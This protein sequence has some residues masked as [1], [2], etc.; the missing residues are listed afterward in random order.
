MFIVIT[1]DYKIGK[2]RAQIYDDNVNLKWTGHKDVTARLNW[3]TDY[4][5]NKETGYFHIGRD[6]WYS[7]TGY[8]KDVRFFY[9]TILQDTSLKCVAD[10]KCA[11]C[12]KDGIETDKC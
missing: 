1:V 6:K 8:I 11:H 10:Y 4:G 12:L 9:D 3:R 2:Y 5:I 7:F